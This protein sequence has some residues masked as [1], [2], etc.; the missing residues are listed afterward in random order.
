M[1]KAE[2]EP[3][4]DEDLPPD[5]GLAVADQPDP[6]FGETD[7]DIETPDDDEPEG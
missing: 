6:A 2:T 4:A 7:E 5:H 1:A 3:R